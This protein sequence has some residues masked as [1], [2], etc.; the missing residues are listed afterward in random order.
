MAEDE[1]LEQ[2]IDAATEAVAVQASEL[3]A[4]ADGESGEPIGFGRGLGRALAMLPSV[5]PLF[6]GCLWMLW[7]SRNETWH[8][9]IA[10]T[11]VIRVR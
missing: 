8:D 3:D 1:N 6:L 5:A 11:I 9:K 4:Q 10:G 7:D 2:A